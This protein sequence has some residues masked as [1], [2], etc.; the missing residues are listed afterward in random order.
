M[1]DVLPSL[2]TSLTGKV[3]LVTGGAIRVGR[4]IGMALASRGANIAFTYLP[5]EPAEEA[6]AEIAAAAP[7]GAAASV[8]ALPMDVREP[9]A[10]Q[11]AVEQVIARFG[12]LDILVNNASVWLRA[13]FLDIT[14]DDWQ[15]ALDINLTGPFLMSQAV[16]PQMLKQESGLIVS[17]TD[18]SAYQTWP[19]YA[20]HAATKAGLVALTRVMAAELA[21]HV[22]VNAIAPGT[23]LLPEGAG[24]AKV[25]WAVQ[26]SLLKRVGRPEDVARTVLF[27]VDSDF[28]TGAVYFVDGGRALV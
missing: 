17:I 25:N 10:P 21:P 3:A 13:P 22:R 6:S 7:A 12:R 14:R 18:L 2:A 23:V 4:V 19:G 27:L 11:R 20:H 15:A 9:G 16:A 8:L 24:E 28:T 5:G 26:N 1:T